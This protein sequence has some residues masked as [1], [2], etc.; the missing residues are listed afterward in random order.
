M[1]NYWHWQTG[2]RLSDAELYFTV[3]APQTDSELGF[4]RQTVPQPSTNL[5][6]P[7]QYA[8]LQA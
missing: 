8:A 1:V 6:E 5:V 4:Q 3:G 7:A 2:W